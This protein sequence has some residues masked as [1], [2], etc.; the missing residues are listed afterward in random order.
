MKVPDTHGSSIAHRS[1][2]LRFTQRGAFRAGR[3]PGPQSQSTGI[4]TEDVSRWP[5]LCQE[6]QH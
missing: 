5:S 3:S 6:A 1:Q 4:L 2:V